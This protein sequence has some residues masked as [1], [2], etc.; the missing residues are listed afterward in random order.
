MASVDPGRS[1]PSG[2][3]A[4]PRW[5]F[6]T[7]HFLVLVS[8]AANHD[9]RVRDIAALV[10]ITER[11]TQ[12]ILGDLVQDGY[13]E[14]IRIGRR[15]RYKIRRTAG[16][17]L[18]EPLRLG[19]S[20]HE[21]QLGAPLEVLEA[22]MHEDAEMALFVNHLRW[23]SGRANIL[24][25]VGSGRAS[26]AYRAAVRWCEWLDED[27]LLVS[28]RVRHA[29]ERGGFSEGSVWWLDEFRDGVV[30][31]VQGF[32]HEADARVAFARRST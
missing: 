12:A 2:G 23:I 5:T 17:R 11:A 19:L 24:A 25:A 29:L 7:N 14:R 31:R 13:V 9:L 30:W 28:G 16:F 32:K 4:A 22:L 8:I 1:A 20:V 18:P 26:D 6:V 10:G 15:N 21:H 3:D 27:T